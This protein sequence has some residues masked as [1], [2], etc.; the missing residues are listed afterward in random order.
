[1]YKNDVVVEDSEV[2]V[3]EWFRSQKER[4]RGHIAISLQYNKR[5]RQREEFSP[6]DY[7]LPCVFKQSSTEESVVKLHLGQSIYDF[8]PYDV[9]DNEHQTIYTVMIPTYIEH[10]RSSQSFRQE[11]TI[12]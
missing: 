11:N 7:Q 9:S 12:P 8:G 10:L 5:E 2:L 4:T 6:A 1:V 3:N